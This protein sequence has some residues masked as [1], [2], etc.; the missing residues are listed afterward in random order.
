[1][2]QPCHAD[3]LRTL[4]LF[5]HLTDEQL[6]LLC[7]QGRIE[8]YPA[9]ELIREGD[10]ATTF[11]VMLEGELVMS[12]RLGNVDIQTRRTTQRGAYCGAWSAYVPEAAQAYEVSIRLVRPS[13]FYVLDAPAFAEF[14]RS[15]FPMAVHLLTGHKLGAVRQQQLVGQRAR[16][17]GLGTITAGLT[18]HLNNPAAAIVR[19]A[20][21]LRTVIGRLRRRPAAIAAG[22]FGT[23]ALQALAKAEDDVAQHIAQPGPESSALEAADREEH[24]ADWLDAHGVDDAWDCAPAFAEAG[25]DVDWMQR[26]TASVPESPTPAAVAWL[27]DTV[28]TELRLREITEASRR[29]A[30]LLAGAEQYSQ[31]DRGSYQHVDVHQL[32]Q[33]TLLMFQG[34]LGTGTGVSVVTDFARDLPEIGC[35][36]GDLNQVWTNILQNALEAVGGSGTITLRTARV[37]D[38]SIRVELCDDGPGIPDHVIDHVF[39]PFF[40]TKP[41]GEGSGLGLDLAWRIVDRHGGH[42]TVESRPGD[43]RFTV[44]LPLEVSEP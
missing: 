7:E 19:A 38:G 5:E 37:N 36:A 44:V 40:T 9:G 2:N 29:I 15:Q 27:K 17:M 8:T 43:T 22:T 30:A 24:L 34:R 41:V 18:H 28:D 39:T 42:L 31:M 26:T 35:Y 23:A 25:V 1:M 14:M 16:L 6:A 13:T 33:S 4:F 11:Y 20:D 21:D 32:L 10:P 3:V 12:G